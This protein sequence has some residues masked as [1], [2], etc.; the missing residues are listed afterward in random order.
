MQRSP[1]RTRLLYRKPA[2]N[3]SHLSI[4]VLLSVSLP[5][6]G[7]QP[8]L[9]EPRCSIFV[10][11][12]LA[13][14]MGHSRSSSYSAWTRVPLFAAQ[15]E[16]L[17]RHLTAFS[18]RLPSLC[19]GLGAGYN[20]SYGNVAKYLADI[21]KRPAEHAKFM[22]SQKHFIQHRVE[23]PGSMRLR[24]SKALKGVQTVTANKETGREWSK[25]WDFVEKDV[26][27]E[28]NP[29]SDPAAQ[30]WVTTTL[31]DGTEVEGV[32]ERVGKKG[33]HRCTDF[34]RSSV[35]HQTE[36]ENGESVLDE[37]QAENK[38]NALSAVFKKDTKEAEK[39][40]LDSQQLSDIIKSLS[41]STGASSSTRTCS[42]DDPELF[43]QLSDSESESD[44]D[45]DDAGRLRRARRRSKPR[46]DLGRRPSRYARRVLL[47]PVVRM[48]PPAR[49]RRRG[50]RHHHLQ[51]LCQQGAHPRM[52]NGRL[53]ASMGGPR[54]FART[55]THRSTP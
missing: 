5:G 28:E 41:L 7:C 14:S 49:V 11:A 10:I 21:N 22:R 3:A 46:L 37:K 19:C 48:L 17:L 42:E 55:S 51:R 30:T 54:T 8:S 33:R 23:N 53:L 47:R 9:C 38:Y 43:R 44:D 36:V 35:L 1:K 13:P 52:A 34:T 27:I 15:S 2:R 26:W 6:A 16:V 24:D 12:H 25:V 40:A 39:T 20:L 29:D 32:W 45:G 31:E 50:W 18:L 4:T